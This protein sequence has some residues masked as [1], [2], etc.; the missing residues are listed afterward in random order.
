M[1]DEIWSKRWEDWSPKSGDPRGPSDV[2]YSRVIHSGSFRRLQGKTQVLGL[3]ESDFYRTRLT[4]SLEVAQ[5]AGGLAKIFKARHAGEPVADALPDRPTIQAIGMTHDLGHP[6]FGHGGEVALNYCMRG[7]GGFEGNGQ[8]LRI[9][10]SLEK[11]SI[12]AGAN[13]TRRTLLGVLKYPIS[14]SAARNPHTDLQ[15]KLRQGLST[16]QLLDRRA[17]KPPKCYMDSE[18]K[19]VDWILG[20]LSDA[21][22]ALFT[23][24]NDGSAPGKPK[25]RTAQHKSLDCSIMDLADDISF[26]VHDLEDGIALG[27]LGEEALRDHIPDADCAHFIAHLNEEYPRTGGDDGA[28]YGNDVYGSWLKFLL[29]GGRHRKRQISRMVDYLMRSSFIFE[30]DRFEEPLLR[31]RAKLHPGARQFLDALTKANREAIIFSPTVQQME[32]RGQGLVIAVF[33]ALCTEP[34]KFLPLDTRQLW[35]ES[36][37]DLRVICDYVAGMT[38]RHLQRVYERLFSPGVGSMFD[39]A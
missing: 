25:H 28:P 22:R 15:P 1:V 29:S 9:L 5:I 35:A 2:D 24:S 23:S 12:S 34:E 14:F 31:Y 27:L 16:V 8:T 7:H 38:D 37:K 6:P 11:F 10:S 4:H 3:G 26:G 13:L 20:P 33:E 21:D 18:Q 17:S 30:D 19:V 36:G 39:K 32:L